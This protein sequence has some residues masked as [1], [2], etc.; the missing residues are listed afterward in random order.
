MK[1]IRILRTGLTIGLDMYREGDLVPATHHTQDLVQ[2][3]DGK[4]FL[5]YRWAEWVEEP[6]AQEPAPEPQHEPVSEPVTQVEEIMHLVPEQ[7]ANAPEAEP[8]PVVDATQEPAPEPAPAPVDLAK[9]IKELIAAGGM[10]KTAIV[11]KLAEPD[12]I[13]QRQ[14]LAVF[15]EL[16]ATGQVVATGEAGVYKVQG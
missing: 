11:K 14:V 1:H 15:D 3:A 9:A 8:A 5:G 4:L 12:N 7:M 10:G 16:L 6:K 2:M 13:S